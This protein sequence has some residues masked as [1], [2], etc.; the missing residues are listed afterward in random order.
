MVA[1]DSAYAA[2]DDSD[3]NPQFGSMQRGLYVAGIGAVLADVEIDGADYSGVG[4]GVALGHGAIDSAIVKA[5]NIFQQFTLNP[6]LF[7]ST[8]QEG[9]LGYGISASL[10]G[11]K[12]LGN[13]TRAFYSLGV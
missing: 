1:L 12:K 2:F 11:G 8:G 3:T 10:N 13:S 9:Q 5:G 4:A 7:Y 6:G